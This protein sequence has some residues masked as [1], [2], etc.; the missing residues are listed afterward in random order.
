MAF[1]TCQMTRTLYDCRILFLVD[2]D[3]LAKNHIVRLTCLHI[4]FEST[5]YTLFFRFRFVRKGMKRKAS[6]LQ[7][8]ASTNAAQM[9]QAASKTA[10]Q[11]MDM[12]NA[13]FE[14]RNLGLYIYIYSVVQQM[15]I[16]CLC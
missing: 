13:T 7:D 4:F 15:S 6:E 5:N 10:Q 12:A 3:F 14:S 2:S 1:G 8:L 9:I 11:G 16:K